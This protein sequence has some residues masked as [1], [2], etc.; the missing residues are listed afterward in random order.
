MYL[1]FDARGKAVKG[2]GGK[3]NKGG[4][5]E[6]GKE[7]GRKDRRKEDRQERGWDARGEGH[8]IEWEDNVCMETYNGGRLETVDGD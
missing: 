5:K 7:G 6:G 4:R 2:A 3:Q 1:S 8:R